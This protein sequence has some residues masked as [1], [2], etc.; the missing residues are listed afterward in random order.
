MMVV[1]NHEGDSVNDDLKVKERYLLVLWLKSC[2]GDTPSH[3]KPIEIQVIVW[4]IPGD[5][6]L[7]PMIIL[8][9]CYSLIGVLKLDWVLIPKRDVFL[10][11]CQDCWTITETQSQQVQHYNDHIG[12]STCQELLNASESVTETPIPLHPITSAWTVQEGQCV[13]SQESVTLT[14]SPTASNYLSVNCTGRTMCHIA[15]V[16]HHD[17]QSHCIQLPQCELYRTM[18]HT[19][20]ISQWDHQFHCTQLPQC[21]LYRKD[22]VSH[23]KNQS[24]WPPIPLHPIISV[25]TV[26]GNALT[27]DGTWR[28]QVT[29]DEK[30]WCDRMSQIKQLE[31]ICEI[32]RG[33]WLFN[34]LKVRTILYWAQ[35]LTRSQCRARSIGYVWSDLAEW[36][37]R[38]A[39]LLWSF[40][41]LHSDLG[42]TQQ[43]AYSIKQWIKK[44]RDYDTGCL[45]YYIHWPQPELPVIINNNNSHFLSTL[46]HQQRVSTLHFTRS[47][48]VHI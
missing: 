5:S 4:T 10:V 39:A 30:K 31:K 3:I 33:A 35:G 17:H 22:N 9:P 43:E 26:Q 11:H 44:E 47:A 36:Q 19:A 18:Y 45:N 29:A 48:N 12:L 14:T 34:N 20:G 38:W 24:Q 2:T 27:A 1:T 13:T 16:S 25:W 7:V 6:E 15:G 40:W 23:Q 32:G 28:S 42:G 41:T 37:K 8:E 46:S 21:E